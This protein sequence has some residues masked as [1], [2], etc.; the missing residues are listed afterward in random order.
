MATLVNYY[1]LS[2]K[3]DKQTTVEV[4]LANYMT[5]GGVVGDVH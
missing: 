1:N 3:Y 2:V 5:S 4:V